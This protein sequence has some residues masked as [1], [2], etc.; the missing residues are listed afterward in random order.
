[1]ST[2]PVT[3]PK[4]VLNKDL[5]ILQRY[6][7]RLIVQEEVLLPEEDEDRGQRLG[8]YMA[9]TRSVG[10]T[11]AEAVSNILKVLFVKDR[12]CDCPSCRTRR[13]S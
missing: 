7:M 6:G 1:M 11:D 13:G 8:E 4:I 12:R 9:I 2:S 5:I 3:D 10:L